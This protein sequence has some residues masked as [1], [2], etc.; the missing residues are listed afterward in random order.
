LP[1]EL[2][3]IV[4]GLLDRG[5]AWSPNFAVASASVAAAISKASGTAASGERWS[6]WVGHRGL[7][8]SR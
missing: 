4:E 3:Q 1:S 6:F 8:V 5:F 2:L 7:S